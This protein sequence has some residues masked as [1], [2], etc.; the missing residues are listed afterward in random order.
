[1]T[2]SLQIDKGVIRKSK[3]GGC[4]PSNIFILMDVIK[5]MEVGDSFIMPI[6]MGDLEPLN[7]ALCLDM[8]GE[9]DTDLTGTRRFWRTA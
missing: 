5:Q 9:T 6:G 7:V 4:A 2:V 1:M 3:A 8:Y